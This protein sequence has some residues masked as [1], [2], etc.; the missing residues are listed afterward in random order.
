MLQNAI[1]AMPNIL[2]KL[3]PNSQPGGKLIRSNETKKT[4][5]LAMAKVHF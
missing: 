3:K 4:Q 5:N 2:D 1:F